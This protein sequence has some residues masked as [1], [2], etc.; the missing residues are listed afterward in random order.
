MDAYLRTTKHMA[1]PLQQGPNIMG[2]LQFLFKITQ[3]SLHVV[4]K[5]K[6][7]REKAAL[8]VTWGPHT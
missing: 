1:K 4:Q 3:I 6:T 2:L 7:L 5:L 8:S